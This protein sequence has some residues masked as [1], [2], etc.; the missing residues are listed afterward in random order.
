M[1]LSWDLDTIIFVTFLIFT[2]VVGLFFSRGIKNINEYAIGNRNFSTS[3]ITA[4]LIATCIGGGFFSGAVSESYKQGLYFIIPAI[5][6]PLALIIVGYL[7]APRMAEFLGNLS[8]A[9]AMGTLYGKKV[10]LV[11]AIVGIFLCTGIVASQFKVSATMLQLFFNVS[12]FYAVLASAVIVIVY[13]AFGG[14]KAVTFTD[15]I[16][17]FTFG[18]IVP[19]I[20][21][22]IWGTMHDSHSVFVTIKENPLFD[23]RQ[24]FSFNFDSISAFFL[25]LFFLIPGFQPVFFQRLAMAKN[26]MQA[27]QSFIIAGLI[28]LVMLVIIMWV[29]ILLLADNPNLNPNNLLAHIIENY[30]Y[31]GLRGLT[32]IGIIAII[33]ST[34]DSYINS[35]AIL[36]TNDILKLLDFKIIANQTNIT[37]SLREATLVATKQSRLPRPLRSLATTLGM[38]RLN[39]LNDLVVLRVF[40]IFVGISAIFLAFKAKSIFDLL[41][42][43]LG[44]YMPVVSVPFLLAILGFRSSSKAVLTGMFAGFITVVSFKVLGVKMK[45]IVPAMVA[46][47]L[48]LMFIHYFFKQAGGWIGVKD[49]SPI[50]ALRLERKRKFRRIISLIKQFNLIN[51]CK[52]NLPKNEITYFLFGFFAIISTYSSLFTIS[53][54]YST[55]YAD[56]YHFIYHSVLIIATGLAICPIWPHKFRNESF[57]ALAWNLG[58]LYLL[59]CVGIM[60]IMISE[61]HQLQLMIFI[62]NLLVTGILLRWQIALFITIFGTFT[63]LQFF[64]CCM[65]KDYL[66]SNLGSIQ[67]QINLFL[68]LLSSVSIAFLKPKLKYEELYE[69]MKSA[70]EK[71]SRKLTH[72]LIKVAQH[73]EEFFSRIEGQEQQQLHSL[74]LQLKALYT[75]L[76]KTAN[77]DQISRI[78]EDLCEVAKRIEAGVLYLSTI[79]HRVR[80]QVHIKLT[81]VNIMDLVNEVVVECEKL[82]EQPLRFVSQYKIKYPNIICDLEKLKEVIKSLLIHAINN[83]VDSNLVGIFLEDDILD[84]ELNISKTTKSKKPIEA[85]RL[86]IK[87]QGDHL[88]EQQLKLIF[89]PTFRQTNEL[90]F[91]ECSN[92]IDAHYGNF[93]VDNNQ[94]KGIN[95]NITI[96]ANIKEIRPKVMDLPDIRIENFEKITEIFLQEQK[97]D[98]LNIAQKLLKAG[99]DFDIIEQATLIK[100]EEITNIKVT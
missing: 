59:I 98:R 62:I 25:L 92:I 71:K 94:G 34:A 95:Y 58:V 10:Q 46:N 52:G 4:T 6:E 2:L 31:Q 37:P 66:T 81:K 42:E 9:E 50:I 53:E 64:K 3:T 23:Y 17:F 28:C 99:V 8:I 44:F 49:P 5:G 60:L 22:I 63:S 39:S 33:M 11:T 15:I 35:S 55:K 97:D 90:T 27:R 40:A 73:E 76:Q 70:W 69:T 14:I 20:T 83:N 89:T 87:D 43:I 45:P 51:F 48:T 54:S 18:T 19:V 21:L 26:I 41:L 77:K 78:T 74:Q 67:F 100:K 56:I 32:A 85:I 82:S 79:T 65:G 80:R 88:T 13:S 36:F 29:G 38:L 57:M 47:L 72:D 75:K 91:F 86:T 16:Q 1:H 96:P 24:L 93:K 61:F 30:S 84:F 68:L 12:S 7:L